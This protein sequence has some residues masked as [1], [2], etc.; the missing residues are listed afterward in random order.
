MACTH[1]EMPKFADPQDGRFR[2]LWRQL[3]WVTDNAL[4]Q[5]QKSQDPSSVEARFAELSN[6]A[7][8]AGEP[9]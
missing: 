9:S 7:P 2:D 4:A 5:A 3:D 6:L 1:T 8:P